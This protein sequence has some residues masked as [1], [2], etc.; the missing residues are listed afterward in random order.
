MLLS[1][2][3]LGGLKRRAVIVRL[4]GRMLDGNDRPASHLGQGDVERRNQVSS[5]HLSVQATGSKLRAKSCTGLRP[6]SLAHWVI[7]GSH[8]RQVER[9]FFE[10][11]AI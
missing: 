9:S 4:T 6:A 3:L 8:F 7:S 11:T 5:L 2:S 1:Y 10:A